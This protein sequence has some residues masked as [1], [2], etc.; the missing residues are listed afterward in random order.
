MPSTRF[1]VRRTA[2]PSTPGPA[3]LPQAQPAHGQRGGPL[4]G[5]IGIFRVLVTLVDL[6]GQMTRPR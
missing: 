6:M 3:P 1:G 5:S 2:R 4:E